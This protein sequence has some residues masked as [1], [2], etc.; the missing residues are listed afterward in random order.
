MFDWG[1]VY[2]KSETISGPVSLTSGR[3]YEEMC[4]GGHGIFIALSSLFQKVLEFFTLN[5]HDK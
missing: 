5:L 1:A 3:L 4:H 2:C